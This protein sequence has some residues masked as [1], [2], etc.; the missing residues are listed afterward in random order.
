MHLVVCGYSRA[1]TTLFYAMLRAALGAG[2]Q[3]F[4]RERPALQVGRSQARHICS[5]RPLDVLQAGEILQR[6]RD[7]WL[8][9]LVRDPR[10]ALT[11]MHAS[12]PDDF[13]VHADCQYFVPRR[14][15]PRRTSP[16]LLSID[17]AIRSLPGE[18]SWVLRYEDLVRDPADVQARLANQLGLTFQEDLTAWQNGSLSPNLRRALNGVRPLDASGVG[19]WRSYPDRIREQFTAY[20]ELHDVLRRRGYEQNGAWWEELCC[21]SPSF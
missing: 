8:I 18:R 10:D 15:R 12:V 3:T 2:W 13:F 1:G 4:D 7:P 17:R 9:A 20:P 11:S 21:T 14:G 6:C 16:G 19:R 5:K